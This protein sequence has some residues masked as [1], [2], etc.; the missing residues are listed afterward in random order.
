MPG[1]GKGGQVGRGQVVGEGHER[2]GHQRQTAWIHWRLL[3]V[4]VPAL[5]LLLLSVV[6][7]LLHLKQDP[8]SQRV[9]VGRETPQAPG[10][11]QLT[12]FETLPPS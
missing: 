5:L 3:L 6:V 2:R 7:G 11:Q 10:H 9:E 4:L 8:L 1:V 12:S